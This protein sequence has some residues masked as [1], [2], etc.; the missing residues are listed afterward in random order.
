MNAWLNGL[1]MIIKEMRSKGY[2]IHYRWDI[3]FSKI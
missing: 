3:N 2:K 1:K